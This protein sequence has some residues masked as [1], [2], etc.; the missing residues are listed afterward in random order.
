MH[1]FVLGLALGRPMAYLL[2]V[3]AHAPILKLYSQGTNNSQTSPDSHL[4]SLD[5]VLCPCVAMVE[6]CTHANFVH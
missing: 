5:F 1:S 2:P 3:T 4:L 6:E